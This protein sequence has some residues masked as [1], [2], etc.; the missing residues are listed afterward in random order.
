MLMCDE[1]QS[2]A[3]QQN[4]A[5]KAQ[6]Q[7]AVPLT[8]KG[9]HTPKTKL[10]SLNPP[11]HNMQQQPM[12]TGKRYF[13]MWRRVI[14]TG[15]IARRERGMVCWTG[16]GWKV[17]RQ[18]VQGIPC[19]VKR[20]RCLRSMQA[21]A[22][23]SKG[24]QCLW[25]ARSSLAVL[26]ANLSSLTFPHFCRFYCTNI[27]GASLSKPHIYRLSGANAM[28][29]CLYINFGLQGWRG[30]SLFAPHAHVSTSSTLANFKIILAVFETE[31]MHMSPRFTL[32]ENSCTGQE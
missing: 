17:E 16:D 4:Q 22:K 29:Y 12:A 5:H 31:I 1:N 2:G 6:K 23:Q 11:K 13:P 9:S 27:I 24:R 30:Q 3:N 28:V 20:K 32:M 19:V 21:L 25:F 8:R 26:H 18:Y 14:A 15:R 10:R 7:K